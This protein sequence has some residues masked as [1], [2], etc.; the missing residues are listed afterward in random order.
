MR[1]RHVRAILLHIQ[2]RGGVA[3]ASTSRSAS[4][5]HDPAS[6]RPCISSHCS[7]CRTVSRKSGSDSASLDT[8][9]THAGA[10]KLL[11]GNGVSRVAADNL[12]PVTQW[13]GASK[14]VPVCSPQEKLFQ[15]Q[16]G[17]R[18]SYLEISSRR[19]GQLLPN[20][21]GS[22]MVA[23]PASNGWLKSTTRIE[24]LARA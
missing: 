9:I 24:P 11:R 6:M 14:C 19:N 13:M 10:K 18:A 7:T 23:V 16:A 20:S 8:S 15:Y 21:G 22:A 1:P 2:E 4:D 5:T 17:P 12:F 3:C